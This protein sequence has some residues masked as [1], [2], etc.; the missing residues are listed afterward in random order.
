MKLMN[1]HKL[2]EESEPTIYNIAY[3]TDLLSGL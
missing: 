2:E 3:L 1:P